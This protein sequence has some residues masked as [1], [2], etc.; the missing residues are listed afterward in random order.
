MEKASLVDI[1]RQFEKPQ[2]V[3]RNLINLSYEC[4]NIFRSIAALEFKLG[5]LGRQMAGLCAREFSPTMP[6]GL[7][8]H[9]SSHQPI[10]VDSSLQKLLEV[11]STKRGND[12]PPADEPP[13]CRKKVED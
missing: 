8:A 3:E 6:A 1:L 5:D 7:G 4:P 10:D 2:V 13:P 12:N 9:S 11:A